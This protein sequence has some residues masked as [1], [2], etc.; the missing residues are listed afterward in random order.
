MMFRGTEKYS[1]EQYSDALKA[2][3]PVPTPTPGWTEPYHMTGNAAKLDKMFELEADRFMNLKY[4]VQDF[5]TD[6]RAA[7][8]NTRKFCSPL[9]C[10]MKKWMI[11]PSPPIPINIPPWD[12]LKISWYAQSVWIFYWILQKI[13][14]SGICNNSAVGDV[15]S[16]KVNML[17]EK[18][19]GSWQTGNYVAKIPA[20]PGSKGNE[21]HTCNKS[22]F[23]PVVS[24]QL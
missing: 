2:T 1:K 5:K 17:A 16:E 15:T 12:F 23:P 19:F 24:I 13:L 20:E 8:E 3:E 9:C 18:Y 4:S 11:S 7:K 6:S 21:I 14:S 22:E 10:W